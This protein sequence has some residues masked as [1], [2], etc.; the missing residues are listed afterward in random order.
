MQPLS[1]EYILEE[2]QKRKDFITGVCITGGEPTLYYFDLIKLIEDI[3]IACPGIKVKI[4]T[5]GSRPD[6]LKKL[7]E[8][9][10]LDFISMD[11]K[12]SPD[13]Y[14][15]YISKYDIEEAII[16]SI[17]T[18][19]ESGIPYEFRTTVLRDHFD[20][21]IAKKMSKYLK[22][23]DIL[24]IQ[25]FKYINEDSHINIKTC[26]DPRLLSFNLDE[27]KEISKPLRKK[28]DVRYRNF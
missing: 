6:V 5:N 8:L 28:C 11:F 1:K 12:T 9:K 18:I 15:G 17:K 20:S 7:Y 14:S 10:L 23:N 21:T 4:D 22:E 26:D 3:K 16:D 13:E 27:I 25:N 19:Q 24:Y 2:L